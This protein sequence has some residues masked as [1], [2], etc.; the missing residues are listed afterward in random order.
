MLR[1]LAVCPISPPIPQSTSP[2][3]PVTCPPLLSSRS[4]LAVASCLKVS[5]RTSVSRI[6]RPAGPCSSLAPPIA[7]QPS[8]T[9][10]PDLNGVGRFRQSQFRLSGWDCDFIHSSHHHP[11]PLAIQHCPRICPPNGLVRACASCTR[12]ARRRNSRRRGNRCR[13][14]SIVHQIPDGKPGRC[15]CATKLATAFFPITDCACR[16]RRR[17][18][19][20]CRGS[21]CASARF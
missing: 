8:H 17:R 7:Y 12:P 5:L 18:R 3:S 4:P 10:R 2:H 20:A 13:A 14:S 21:G 1:S 11:L 9:A 15:R 6:Q 19:R 16:R